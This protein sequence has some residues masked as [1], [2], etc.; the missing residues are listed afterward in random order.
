MDRR[1]VHAVAWTYPDPAA[2]YELL[3]D[4][5]A[6]YPGRVDGAWLDHER[7]L[8]REGD[9]YG[10]WVAADLI[11]PFKDAPGTQRW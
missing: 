6:F 2:A 1:L 4:H 8:A 3:R 5:I 10:G 7:V 9:F 11:G